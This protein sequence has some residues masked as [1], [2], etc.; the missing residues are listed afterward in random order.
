VITLAAA[1]SLPLTVHGGAPFPARDLLLLCAYICVLVTLVPPGLTLGPLLRRLGF[2]DS[3]SGDALLRNQARAAAVE[4]AMARLDQLSTSREVSQ[5]VAGPLRRAATM[6]LERYSNRIDRLS[7]AEDAS[8]PPDDPYY[9]GV[10]ARR[11]MIDAERDELLQ[12]RDTGRLSERDLR[13]LQRELDHEEGL[14]PPR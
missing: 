5:E 11:S 12:W 1:F 2:E 9:A 10:R 7:S 6:R 8:L 3:S 13:I 14:L 4:A